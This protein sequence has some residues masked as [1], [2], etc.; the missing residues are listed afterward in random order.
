[1]NQ[2]AQVLNDFGFT[3]RDA[4][5][6]AERAQ[7]NGLSLADIQAWIDEAQASTSLHNPLGFVRA[8]LQDGDRL[9]P[10]ARPDCH[11][12][13]RRRYFEWDPSRD[14]EYNRE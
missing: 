4:K 8:R 6:I 9:P 1:M 5:R 7:K 14:K 11:Q 10:A 12:T 13:N 2:T 3:A